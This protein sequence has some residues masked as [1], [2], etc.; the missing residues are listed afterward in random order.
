MI[1]PE[2][3]EH[4]LKIILFGS[5]A[6]GQAKEDSDL[7]LLIIEEIDLPRHQR[8]ARYLRALTGLYPAKDILV[9]TPEEI[10]SWAGVSNAFITTILREGKILYERPF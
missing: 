5:Q 10:L 4:S 1:D 3:L 2:C 9:W 8:A 7:D 6:S